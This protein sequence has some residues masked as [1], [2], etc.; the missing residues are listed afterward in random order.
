MWAEGSDLALL[1]REIGILLAHL[2]LFSGQEDYWR[3]RLGNVQTAIQ[4]AKQLPDAQ[5]GVYIG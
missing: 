4:F 5:G 1:E 2:D 3:I